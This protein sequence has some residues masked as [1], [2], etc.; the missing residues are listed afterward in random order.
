MPDIKEILNKTKLIHSYK[1]NILNDIMYL[2]Q[3]ENDL[4]ISQNRGANL[5]DTKNIV[6]EQINNIQINYD[7]VEK[8]L[9]NKYFDLQLLNNRMINIDYSNLLNSINVNTDDSNEVRYIE[10]YASLLSNK[11]FLE[12]IKTQL[13][14]WN[15]NFDDNNLLD[16]NPI[17]QL[18]NDI[19]LGLS[20]LEQ[21]LEQ[22]ISRL[23]D[24]STVIGESKKTGEIEDIGNIDSTKL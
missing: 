6:I 14:E 7:L 21:T 3:L 17:L 16:T 5:G 10:M 20:E 19:F 15:N 18:I 2:R 4:D 12:G 9:D 8:I 11:N 23:Y 1:L 24:I 22:A 13:E